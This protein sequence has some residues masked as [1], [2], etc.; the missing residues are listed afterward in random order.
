MTLSPEQRLALRQMMEH[1]GW[2]VLVEVVLPDRLRFIADRMA[3]RRY[4]DFAQVL[5]DQAEY[6]ALSNFPV[7]VASYLSANDR[8]ES[9]SDHK[10]TVPKRGD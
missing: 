2:K 4:E 9:R 10:G 7:D 1:A 3:L 8:A 6:R 5:A